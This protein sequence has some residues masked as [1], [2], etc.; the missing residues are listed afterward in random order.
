MQRLPR[1]VQLKDIL[2]VFQ[3]HCRTQHFDGRKIKVAHYL[4]V[5]LL[6]WPIAAVRLAAG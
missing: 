1:T 5:G 2:T 4:L 6:S 3:E